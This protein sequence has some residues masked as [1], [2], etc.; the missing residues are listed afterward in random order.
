MDTDTRFKEDFERSIKFYIKDEGVVRLNRFMYKTKYYAKGGINANGRD[1]EKE[2]RDA[3]I[4]KDKYP[5][6]ITVYKKKT[7]RTNIRLK[8]PKKR[9]Q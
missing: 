6:Y 1:V 2:D 3:K 7:G 8:V 5:D 9:K 4:L